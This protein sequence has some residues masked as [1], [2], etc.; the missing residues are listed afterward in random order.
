MIHKGIRE[1][2]DA[3]ASMECAYCLVSV[4]V[5][6][7]LAAT[8]GLRHVLSDWVTLRQLEHCRTIK[9]T[10]SHQRSRIFPQF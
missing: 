8:L 3:T 9:S 4:V 2:H 5:V 6:S 10:Q 1:E 7:V